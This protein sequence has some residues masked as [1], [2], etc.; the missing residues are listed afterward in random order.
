MPSLGW[1][2]DQYDKRD[3]LHKTVPLS[4]LPEKVVLDKYLYNVRNQGNVGACVGFS[5]A[6]VLNAC[7]KKL[8]VYTEWFSPTWIYN[9]ARYIEGTLLFD[10]GCYPRN[11]AKWIKDKGCL[12]ERYWPYNP[13]KLDTTAPPSSLEQYAKQYPIISYYRCVDG[14]DG[15]CSAISDGYY[16]SIGSPWFE[17]WF[18]V[19]K[20][21]ILPPVKVTDNIAGGHATVIYGYDKSK[22]YLYG[23][24]SW[25]IEWG[26]L[27][28]FLMPFESFD[29]FKKLGGYDAYYILVDWKKP[30]EP[31]PRPQPVKTFG[32][33][34]QITY[35]GGETWKSVFEK[36]F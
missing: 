28:L 24:N 27:G 23:V 4:E 15:I 10:V 1:R 5:F 19:P 16:V 29:V 6:G 35:D 17:K 34:L 11:A 26:N 12:L 13:D 20:D 33:R 32:F 14:I 7:A 2:K 31:E 18:Y 22:S 9:G 21:G 8:N 36:I 30:P 3:W 25:G